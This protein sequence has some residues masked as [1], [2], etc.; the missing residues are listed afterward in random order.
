[1]ALATLLMGSWTKSVGNQP[2]GLNREPKTTPKL[3][4]QPMCDHHALAPPAHTPCHAAST[5]CPNHAT[6]LAICLLSP[7]HG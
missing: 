4:P 2:N 1:M 5:S 7:R 3:E 6:S